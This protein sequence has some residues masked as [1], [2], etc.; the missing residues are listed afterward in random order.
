MSFSF[1][2]ISVNDNDNLAAEICQDLRMQQFN[3]KILQQHYVAS[4][5]I[6]VSQKNIKFEEISLEDLY[7]LIT[8]DLSNNIYYLKNVDRIYI[9][10]LLNDKLKL[11]LIKGLE[12]HQLQ[13]NWDQLLEAITNL[14]KLALDSNPNDKIHISLL[15]KSTY[16][17]MFLFHQDELA[18]RVYPFIKKT[19]MPV[20]ESNL[21]TIKQIYDIVRAN[22]NIIYQLDYDLCSVIQTYLKDYNIDFN[23]CDNTLLEYLETILN[24]FS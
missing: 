3:L 5:S 18:K 2:D 9:H 6:Y 16:L 14:N 22:N 4:A 13:F 8:L 21:D 12:N 20:T 7:K 24:Y 1:S 11:P 10:H 17:L 23:N 15:H 19:C